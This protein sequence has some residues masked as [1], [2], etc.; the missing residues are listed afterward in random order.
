M[1]SK[2]LKNNANLRKPLQWPYDCTLTQIKYFLPEYNT[3]FNL[4]PDF[5]LPPFSPL[6]PFL[7]FFLCLLSHFW[8]NP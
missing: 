3:K 4:E 2:V 1:V 7:S 8:K 6:S 5:F